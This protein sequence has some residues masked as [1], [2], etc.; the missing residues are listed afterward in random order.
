MPTSKPMWTVTVTVI[1]WSVV[2]TRWD[3]CIAGN[4]TSITRLL[5][6]PTS[7]TYNLAVCSTGE[8]IHPHNYSFHSNYHKFHCG[9]SSHYHMQDRELQV[10][11]GKFTVNNRNHNSTLKHMHNS[12]SMKH[13]LTYLT[14]WT[15]ES[16]IT[17]AGVV[18]WARTTISTWW[19]TWRNK[20]KCSTITI[21]SFINDYMHHCGCKTLTDIVNAAGTRVSCWTHTCTIHTGSIVVANGSVVIGSTYFKCWLRKHGR[22]VLYHMYS[23]VTRYTLSVESFM[24]FTNSQISQYRPRN[25]NWQLQYP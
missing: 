20:Y 17:I 21:H 18:V 11:R 14:T 15:T 24:E 6:N 9:N 3:A 16:I 22:N 10:S 25:P 7:Q 13:T 12:C 4:I 8:D 5:H 23:L 19:I 1:T 2:L